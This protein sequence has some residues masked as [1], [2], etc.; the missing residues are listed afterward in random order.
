MRQRKTGPGGADPV[1]GRVQVLVRGSIRQPEM[2]RQPH[3]PALAGAGVCRDRTAGPLYANVERLGV[4]QAL[5]AATVPRS[6][7]MPTAAVGP[8][9]G[10]SV[11]ITAPGLQSTQAVKEAVSTIALTMQR[12]ARC[13]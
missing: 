4:T 12:L 9:R 7:P 5:A 1:R 3:P 2:S 8:A 11:S 13:G 6:K 10:G